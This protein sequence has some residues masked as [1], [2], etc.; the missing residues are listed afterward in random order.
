MSN[1]TLNPTLTVPLSGTG[2]MPVAALLPASLA[3]GQQAINTASLAQALVL[4][5]TGT[6]A[7]DITSIGTT[8][9]FVQTN[10]CG[11]S[12]AA[13]ANCAIVVT[14]TPTV[15]GLLN[16]TLTLASNDPFNPSIPIALSGTGDTI[17][18]APNNLLAYN[19]TL[20]VTP[21]TVRLTWVDRS[22]NEAGFQ[23]QR[24]TN[25]AFTLGVVNI[26][27]APDAIT[28]TDTTVVRR[29]AYYYRVRA[30]IPGGNSAWSNT[31]GITTVGQL[32]AAPTGP[33]F[34]SSTINSITMSW[35]NNATNAQGYRI[36]RS[37]TAAGALTQVGTVTNPA[38][39][40]FTNVGLARN[41]SYWYVVRAY[42]ADGNGPYLPKVE[43]KTAP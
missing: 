13:G 29:T 16:G 37:S 38:T 20:A 32:P 1:D 11:P 9:G 39:T 12:L 41:R 22:T 7:L 21:P 19:S 30:F 27:V 25:S 4:S 35:V 33:T 24:A 18:T 17:P 5:N 42:S 43:M 28:F 40:T 31:R 10:A 15:V 2:V 8:S 3:F 6:A 34:V 36:Y 14:F 23:I 26:N